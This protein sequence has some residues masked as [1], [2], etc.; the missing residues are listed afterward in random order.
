MEAVLLIHQRRHQ[1]E[2]GC[3]D[4]LSLQRFYLTFWAQHFVIL[5]LYFT[6]SALARISVFT[7]SL[8]TA[9]GSKPVVYY[10]AVACFK[11]TVLI[12]TFYVVLYFFYSPKTGSF[13]F[14]SPF[15]RSFVDISTM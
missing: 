10:V 3:C 7:L 6:A 9:D 2:L 13:P 12:M 1:L 14:Y 15:S 8:R 5:R 4:A 11:I